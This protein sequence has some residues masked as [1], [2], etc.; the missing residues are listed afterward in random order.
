MYLLNMI[1]IKFEYYMKHVSSAMAY[2]ITLV[3]EIHL[4]IKR[5]ITARYIRRDVFI[6]I[7][8][9]NQPLTSILHFSLLGDNCRDIW[10]DQQIVNQTHIKTVILS[11]RPGVSHSDRKSDRHIVRKTYSQRSIYWSYCVPSSA[12]LHVRSGT[13][14]LISLQQKHGRNITKKGVNKYTVNPIY[15]ARCRGKPPCESPTSGD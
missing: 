5:K 2:E 14:C 7:T 13:R 10:L 4:T 1:C 8:N 12:L 15:K 9:Y 6:D 11:V 3:Q